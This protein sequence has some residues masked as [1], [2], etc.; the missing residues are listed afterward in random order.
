MKCRLE[1]ILFLKMQSL[2]TNRLCFLKAVFRLKVQTVD[3][4]CLIPDPHPELMVLRE[5]TVL[6]LLSR[7]SCHIPLICPDQ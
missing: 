4:R 7:L 6:L 3:F 5:K 2:M 1:P